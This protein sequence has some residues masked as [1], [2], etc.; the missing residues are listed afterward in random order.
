MLCKCHLLL[1]NV[2]DLLA[3]AIGSGEVGGRGGGGGES[4]V[5]FILFGLVSSRSFIMVFPTTNEV[6]L[7]SQ[8]SYTI[9]QSFVPTLLLMR[10][11]ASY[12]GLYFRDMHTFNYA[13]FTQDNCINS[14]GV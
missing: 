3:M 9:K 8:T 14:V 7:Y 10:T 12:R 2:R 1:L 13:L 5:S 6:P 11:V 4:S